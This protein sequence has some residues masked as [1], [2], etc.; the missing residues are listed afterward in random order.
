[1]LIIY[2]DAL[3]KRN[4]KTFKL[5]GR[6]ISTTGTEK[7][8]FL[9]LSDG[10]VEHGKEL[11]RLLQAL[12][13][14][15]VKNLTVNDFPPEVQELEPLIKYEDE[16][17]DD[18]LK[19]R[20]AALR[21]ALDGWDDDVFVEETRKW[22][23]VNSFEHETFVENAICCAG[24]LHASVSSDIFEPRFSIVENPYLKDLLKKI[25]LRKPVLYNKL[26]FEQRDKISEFFNLL[27]QEFA[28]ILFHKDT[29][30]RGVEIY[31]GG[32]IKE[33]V[34]YMHSVYD[35]DYFFAVTEKMKGQE[36]INWLSNNLHAAEIVYRK[37][38]EK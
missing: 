17:W 24:V 30:D 37:G 21:Q 16:I 19:Y 11:E 20:V 27:L 5:I 13:K 28:S 34:F 12:T 10:V 2:T 25:Y 26:L 1:M 35:N 6:Q 23:R 8:I 38:M 7:R 18:S 31:H 15:F 32:A 14:Q 36:V 33:N 3:K 9:K 22:I 29:E 4:N